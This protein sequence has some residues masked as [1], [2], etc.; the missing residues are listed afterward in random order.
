MGK[1][2]LTVEAMPLVESEFA[3]GAR[4]VDL[5]EVVAPESL[6][7]HLAVAMGMRDGA[8]VD[9]PLLME[10]AADLSVL[11]VLD[12][13]EWLDTDCLLV[14]QDL[15]LAASGISL[16]AT[17]RR[18]MAV[19]GG[20]VITVPPLTSP[21]LAV[22]DPEQLVRFEAVELFLDRVRLVRPDYRLTEQQGPSVAALCERV[23]GVPLAIELAASWVRALA[24][25]QIVDRMDVQP[26]FPRS[27][28]TN[29]RH[30]T[31]QALTAGSYDLCTGQ[32]KLLWSRLTVFEGSFEL[33]AAERICAGAPLERTSLL[34]MMASLVDQS[35]IVVDDAGTH[36]RYRLLRM[37]REFGRRQLPSEELPDLRSRHLT[38]YDQALRST[39]RDLDY[40][41]DDDRLARMGLDYTNT[42]AAITHAMADA[43]TASIG[44]SM[45]AELLYYWFASGHLTVG[46]ALLRST[47]ASTDSTAAPLELGQAL[48]VNAYLA[49]LQNELR[50][51]AKLVESASSIDELQSDPYGRGLY[52]HVSALV[53]LNQGRVD[54]AQ[55]ALD[56]AIAVY[57]VLDDDRSRI[58]LMDAFGVA[59]VVSA[60]AGDCERALQ[61]GNR[62]LDLCESVGD[63]RWRGYLEYSLAV[64]R[65]VQ[66]DID[67]AVDLGL[68]VLSYSRDQLLAAHCV[69]LLAWCAEFRGQHVKAA[70]LFGAAEQAWRFLGGMLSGFTPLKEHRTAAFQAC[71]AHLGEDAFQLEYRSGAADR[72]WDS[73]LA[74]VH[75]DVPAPRADALAALTRRER[76]VAELVAEGLSNREIAKRFTISQRTVE[77][78]VEHILA[79]LA[80]DNRTMVARVLYRRA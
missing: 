77:T 49:V 37:M 26:D 69:E 52:T 51:A 55:S 63:R 53:A 33:T 27:K 42:A 30:Q 48:C 4:F 61:L 56:E 38:Y 1:T 41:N 74:L 23:D 29:P 31:L 65:W 16:L 11:I 8:S 12:S 3:D 44:L 2:R 24:V 72:S 75:E 59:V 40:A 5:T 39:N 20:R 6:V 28:S 67:T 68:K 57:S 10:F 70:R 50:S 7:A 36:A 13:C 43:A 45:A 73:V 35:V 80:L 62:G 79:K 21:R 47:I 58:Y 9:L 54:I 71:R 17:S 25:D 18:A 19:D 34:D 32:E 60:L 76:E 64:D 14:L 22:T 46:R 78:H 66:R 15:L